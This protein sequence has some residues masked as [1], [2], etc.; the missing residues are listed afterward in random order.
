MRKILFEEG[1]VHSASCQ[2]DVVLCT[3][4]TERGLPTSLMVQLNKRG[5][6]GISEGRLT[7]AQAEAKE[8][9]RGTSRERLVLPEPGPA[10]LLPLPCQACLAASLYPQTGPP[11]GA[12]L[13]AGPAGTGSHF[14]SPSAVRGRGRTRPPRPADRGGR[15]HAAPGPWLLHWEGGVLGAEAPEAVFST[16]W[17]MSHW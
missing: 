13:G 6:H 14:L 12:V 11:G 5:S 4:Y 2:L 16:V 7:C 3:Q 9:P 1:R 15:F 10:S 17:G 8:E